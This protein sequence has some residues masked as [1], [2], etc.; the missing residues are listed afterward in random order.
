MAIPDEEIREMIREFRESYLPKDFCMECPFMANGKFLCSLCT[1]IF[2]LMPPIADSYFTEDIYYG[3]F[4]IVWV[5]HMNFSKSSH[6]ETCPCYVYGPEYTA[7]KIAEF[8][9]EI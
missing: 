1:R 5:K 7:E 2:N 4:R 3:Y 6:K 9:G 8:M